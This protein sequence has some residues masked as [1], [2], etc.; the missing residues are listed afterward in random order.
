[1]RFASTVVIVV[2]TT[3]GASL[4]LAASVGG[5]YA[6]QIQRNP[7]VTK[8]VTA[9]VVF[10]ASDV[11]AQRIEGRRSLDGLRL[12]MTTAIGGFYFAPAAHFWYAFVTAVLPLT[13]LPH[14]IGKAALGQCIFGPL[15][16]CVFFASAC[17]QTEGSLR[18]LPRKIQ[19]DLLPVQLAGLGYWPFVDIISFS[20]I[21]LDYIPLFIN[22]ASFIWTIFLS[23][24]SR[25]QLKPSSSDHPGPPI[26]D[27]DVKVPSSWETGASLREGLLSSDP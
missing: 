3:T 7:I 4:N 21:P 6:Q 9:A 12:A 15:V 20:L 22:L 14:I 17:L 24:K 1:M 5:L 27:D 25:H 26:K 11:A 16:T 18:S 13:T 10:G 2:M 23:L 19:K 8:S